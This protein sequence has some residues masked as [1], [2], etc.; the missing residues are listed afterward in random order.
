MV[1]I[2]DFENGNISIQLSPCARLQACVKFQPVTNFTMYRGLSPRQ[3]NMTN[4]I[5]IKNTQYTYLGTFL[6]D[7]HVTNLYSI[8]LNVCMNIDHLML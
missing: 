3:A 5:F 8:Y 1:A 6:G 2:L 4:L 7:H